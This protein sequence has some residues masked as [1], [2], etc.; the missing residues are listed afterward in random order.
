MNRAVKLIEVGNGEGAPGKYNY[1]PSYEYYTR[2]LDQGW[3]VAP[4]NNQD[5]HHANWITANP[6]RTV[7]LAH[8]LTR[9][10]I[11][12]AIRYL[13]VYATE[14]RDLLVSFQV[15]GAMMGTTLSLPESLEIEIQVTDPDPADPIRENRADC[16][17]KIPLPPS[18]TFDSATVDLELATPFGLPLLLPENHRSRRRPRRHRPHLDW[19]VKRLKP[20]QPQ[21]LRPSTQTPQR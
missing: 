16:W 9:E 3:H 21:A 10:E 12:D 8:S 1:H 14:D 18:N 17:L 13:R 6:C 20:N 11:Y 5:N 4:S 7:V 19:K 15:N 2:A